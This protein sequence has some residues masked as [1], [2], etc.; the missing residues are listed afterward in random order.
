MFTGIIAEMGFIV[1]TTMQGTLCRLTIRMPKLSKQIHLGDSVSVDGVCLTATKK[2][3]QVV[4]FDAMKETM[5]VTT[6]KSLRPQDKVNLELAMTPQTRMGGHMVTGHI[7][8]RAFISGIRRQKDW[9]IYEIEV[10]KAWRVFII[11]KGSVAF[12]GISLTV[13]KKTS[14]GCECY[15]IPFTLAQTTLSLKKKGDEL[16]FEADVLVKYVQGVLKNLQRNSK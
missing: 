12:D 8:A 2:S 9:V 7:D 3:G 1:S 13:G 5:D 4:H 10:P 14:K 6:L 16:N 11:E 15:L